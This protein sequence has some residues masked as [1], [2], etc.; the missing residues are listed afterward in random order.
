MFG[1]TL[2]E[3]RTIFTNCVKLNFTGLHTGLLEVNIP[4]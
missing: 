4:K 3:R 2:C 1:N